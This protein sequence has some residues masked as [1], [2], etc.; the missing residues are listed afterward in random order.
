MMVTLKDLNLEF[1]FNEVNFQTLAIE[2]NSLYRQ[3]IHS[4]ENNSIDDML[5]FSKN[6]APFEFSKKGIFLP[7]I[8]NPDINNKKLLAKIIARLENIVNDVYFEQLTSLKS[9]IIKFA[10][11]LVTESDFDVDYN[12]EIDFKGLTKLIDL[13]LENKEEA[14]AENFIRYLC[15][16]NQYLGTSLFA[17]SGLHLI[18][19]K[20]ELDEIFETL[21]LNNISVLC[22]EGYAPENISDFEKICIIDRDLCIIK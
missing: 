1:K 16:F 18:F 8:I 2:N 15:L 12:Y 13:R 19:D 9:E 20:N 10:D 17:V 3:V 21:K 7:D 22:I 14:F 11:I 5:V 6:Y 4:F